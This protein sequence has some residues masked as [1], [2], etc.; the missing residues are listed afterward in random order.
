MLE[1]DTLLSSIFTCPCP[2]GM[3]IGTY[4]KGAV[5]KLDPSKWKFEGIDTLFVFQRKLHSRLV[6]VPKDQERANGDDK[7]EDNDDDDE[8]SDVSSIEGE[9]SSM[10]L[11]QWARDTFGIEYS[12]TELTRNMS[13]RKGNVGVVR[14]MGADSYVDIH[15]AG[16]RHLSPCFPQGYFVPIHFPTEEACVEF[17][18][19]HNAA[20]RA[21]RGPHADQVNYLLIQA[22]LDHEPAYVNFFAEN[23]SRSVEWQRLKDRVCLKDSEKR[24][25]VKDDDDDD[26]NANYSKRCRFSK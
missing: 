7:D 15:F 8:C 22:L 18:R 4:L 12:K 19:L 1:E 24:G 11:A 5:L 23:E 6:V 20:R 21:T 14:I 26:E 13:N 3:T 9:S 17:L 16:Y 2:A 25:N 10:D